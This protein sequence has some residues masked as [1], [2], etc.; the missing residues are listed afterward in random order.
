MVQVLTQQLESSD[1]GSVSATINDPP[2]QEKKNNQLHVAFETISPIVR[3]VHHLSLSLS[4]SLE[5]WK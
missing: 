4:L 1:G 3:I 5:G 2:E